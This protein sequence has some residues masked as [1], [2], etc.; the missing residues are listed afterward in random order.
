VELP[1]LRHAKRPGDTKIQASTEK[2]RADEDQGEGTMRLLL[3]VHGSDKNCP[4]SSFVF[5]TITPEYAR[6]ML[7]RRE[8]VRQIDGQSEELGKLWTLSFWDATP[9]WVGHDPEVEA[10]PEFASVLATGKECEDMEDFLRAS[11]GDELVDQVLSDQRVVELPKRFT[12]GPPS[13]RH[14]V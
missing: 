2:T 9:R 3:C 13:R 1:T 12:L 11:L 6:Q 5:L 4:S 8:V 14:R 10:S 7:Q